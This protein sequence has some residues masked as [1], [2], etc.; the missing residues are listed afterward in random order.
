MREAAPTSS[1][2]RRW[3]TVS[4]G[5]PALQDT[6]TPSTVSADSGPEPPVASSS[7]SNA[8]PDSPSSSRSPTSANE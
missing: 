6:A 7:V 2:S 3:R 5:R 1:T 4:T 8:G